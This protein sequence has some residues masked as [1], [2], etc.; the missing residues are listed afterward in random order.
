MLDDVPPVEIKA[1]LA[2]IEFLLHLYSGNTEEGRKLC[3]HRVSEIER[4]REL[5]R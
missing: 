1:V 3:R 2:E 4:A 5:T